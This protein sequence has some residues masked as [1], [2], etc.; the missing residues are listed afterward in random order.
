MFRKELQQL[1][2]IV[3]CTSTTDPEYHAEVVLNVAERLK[4][5]IS[6]YPSEM[7]FLTSADPLDI[8]SLRYKRITNFIEMAQIKIPEYLESARHFREN[9][10]QQRQLIKK[11]MEQADFP[12]EQRKKQMK[13]EILE[14]KSEAHYYSEVRDFRAMAERRGTSLDRC[15]A[16]I[17]IS[18]R[19]KE[20]IK[21]FPDNAHHWNSETA[22]DANYRKIIDFIKRTEEE[23]PEVLSRAREFCRIFESRNLSLDTKKQRLRE[24]AE[25]NLDIL[26][27]QINSEKNDVLREVINGR[28]RHLQRLRNESRETDIWTK[29]SFNQSVADGCIDDVLTRICAGEDVDK[30][31]N[32]ALRLAITNGHLAVAA[33]LIEG[34]ATPDL[35]M[36]DAAIRLAHFDILR[37]LISLGMPFHKDWLFMCCEWNTELFY[38]W[39][40]KGATSLP[41]IKQSAL[42]VIAQ[43]ALGRGNLDV[44]LLAR[45]VGAKLSDLDLELS[46]STLF[47][48]TVLP[49]E[50]LLLVASIARYILNIP[51]ELLK[52]IEDREDSKCSNEYYSEERR[53]RHR[54]F[55]N[56]RNGYGATLNAK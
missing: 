46:I 2:R 28:I 26:E 19:L 12:K 48:S 53:E 50:K 55:T 21:E 18:N 7:I 47:Y 17:N 8:D 16:V 11:N 54:V 23:I 25:A 20:L 30:D 37:F 4:N 34:G 24:I 35:K 31:D 52:E 13:T 5:L 29:P 15:E 36:I 9:Q 22:P 44:F 45:N 49:R 43:T 14:K 33:A 3:H 38:E 32:L 10:N 56:W 39:I 41:P 1:D 6:E 40:I 51:D 42:D 27:E